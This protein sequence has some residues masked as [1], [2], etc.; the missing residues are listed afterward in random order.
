MFVSFFIGRCNQ[1]CELENLFFNFAVHH[2]KHEIV[3]KLCFRWYEIYMDMDLC[4][5][6]RA[7][8]DTSNMNIFLYTYRSIKLLSTLQSNNRQSS[9]KIRKM[10]TPLVVRQTGSYTSR[11]QVLTGILNA[12]ISKK[13]NKILDPKIWEILGFW[14]GCEDLNLV[15]DLYPQLIFQ[16]KSFHMLTQLFLSAS[17]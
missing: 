15:L 10:V 2:F 9:D 13:G 16:S 12:R 11:E 14:F 4:F 17:L 3:V 7:S 5:R 8:D 6:Y 1:F